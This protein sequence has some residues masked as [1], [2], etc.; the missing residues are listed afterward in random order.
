MDMETFREYQLAINHIEGQELLN[1]ISAA[2][3]PNLKKESQRS[4][5]S[6]IKSQMRIIEQTGEASDTEALARA[7]AG[8]LG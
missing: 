6:S 3:Y 7:L 2:S 8:A 4:M 5:S 1:N